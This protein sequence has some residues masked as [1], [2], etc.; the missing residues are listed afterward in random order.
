[1]LYGEGKS[2]FRRL[3]EEIVKQSDDQSI[4]AWRDSQPQKP[5]LA[6]SSSCFKGLGQLRCVYATSDDRTGYTL[7]NSGLS[8]QLM[9]FPWMMNIYL[10]P[11]GCGLLGNKVLINN[12]QSVRGYDRICIFLRQADTYNHF[13]RVTVAG[14]DQIAINSD[15]IATM[16]DNFHIKSK[17]LFLRQNIS[18]MMNLPAPRFHGY[19]FVFNHSSIFAKSSSNLLGITGRSLERY[20][21]RDP[22]PQDALC[23]HQWI[24]EQRILR[25]K[26]PGFHAAGLFR[27]SSV[28]LDKKTFYVFLGFDIDFAPICLITSYTPSL[29]EGTEFDVSI[30]DLSKVGEREAYHLLSLKWLLEKVSQGK[31]ANTFLAFKGDS[32]EP[33]TVT[34]RSLSLKMSFVSV[35]DAALGKEIWTVTFED[36]QG[37]R[38]MLAPFNFGPRSSEN[39]IIV[40]SVERSRWTTVAMDHSK[41]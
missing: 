40:T 20:S 10:C 21:S 4:F 7:A 29:P 26:A 1:M 6:P 8:I 31:D 16:R 34:C 30:S 19:K 37:P 23:I 12:R 33:S 9:T 38:S 18:M 32:S 24:P 13:I 17:R 25:N 39:D 5:I 2:A 36:W 22:K 35:H 28:H 15:S 11:L 41:K 14:E 3:Q 27:L